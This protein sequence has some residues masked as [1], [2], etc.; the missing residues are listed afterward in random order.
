VIAAAKGLYKVKMPSAGDDRHRKKGERVSDSDLVGKP[1]RISDHRRHMK[2]ARRRSVGA[3]PMDGGVDC[4]SELSGDGPMSMP[5]PVPPPLLE[6][7]IEEVVERE[8]TVDV[9]EEEEVVMESKGMGVLGKVV[10]GSVVAAGVVG[11][12]FLIYRRFYRRS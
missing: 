8:V 2:K 5:C 1:K 9:E 7:E 3:K 11:V 4:D 6:M 12:G 10:V